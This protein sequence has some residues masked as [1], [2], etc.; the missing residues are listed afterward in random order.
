[1]NDA[2]DGSERAF[3][4]DTYFLFSLATSESTSDGAH[5]SISGRW[6]INFPI[7]I[8]VEK[9]KSNRGVYIYPK[10][11][12]IRKFQITFYTVYVKNSKTGLPSVEIF[13]ITMAFPSCIAILNILSQCNR[14]C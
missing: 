7:L 13:H 9:I 3:G 5:Q 2:S 1:M 12:F 4:I 11:F 14:K 10:N 6:I 8:R